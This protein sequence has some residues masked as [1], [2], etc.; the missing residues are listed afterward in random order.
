MLIS[1]AT[2]YLA[3]LVVRDL[4]LR[5]R[6]A[7]LRMKTEIVRIV[8]VQF[9]DDTN[10]DWELTAGIGVDIGTLLVRRLGLRNTKQKEVW[11]G[12]PVNMAA[13][14]SSH[15]DS[16]QIMVSDRVFAQYEKFSELRATCLALVV[17]L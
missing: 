6:H 14:L 9:D 10:V 17:W 1:K 15:T 16:N 2:G 11:A 4:H 7:Q 8:A 3:Y 5:R 13:K 12:K